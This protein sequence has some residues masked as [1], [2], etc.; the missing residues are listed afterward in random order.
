MSDRSVLDTV[1]AY[2]VEPE[3]YVR[4]VDSEGVHEGIVLAIEDHGDAITLVLSDD[5]EGDTIDYQIEALSQV[6]ILGFD[7][8]EVA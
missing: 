1:D 3:D 8:L 4:F 6:E 2:A 7:V 5:L